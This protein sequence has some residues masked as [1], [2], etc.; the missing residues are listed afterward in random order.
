[1]FVDNTRDP[2]VVD[3]QVVNSLLECGQFQ[4]SGFIPTTP[5]GGHKG[6]YMWG[7][8]VLHLSYTGYSFQI[9]VYTQEQIYHEERELNSISFQERIS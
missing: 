6:W 2:W 5:Y 9:P 8:K 1:M 7:T 3:L 4:D